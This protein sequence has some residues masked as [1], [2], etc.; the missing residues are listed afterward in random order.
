MKTTKTA[1]GAG[2]LLQLA[3]RLK[4]QVEKADAGPNW[5]DKSLAAIADPDEK[6]GLLRAIQIQRA[7]GIIPE[8]AAFF[9][10]LVAAN[11]IADEAVETKDPE[12]A[13]DESVISIF[14]EYGGDDMADLALA[15]MDA[16]LDRVEAG[17]AWLKPMTSY[18]S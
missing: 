16:F 8:D 13:G 7:A 11:E 15:D 6:G 17:R 9:G 4:D 12:W 2:E 1:A 5:R 3:A 10:I 14:R 18:G